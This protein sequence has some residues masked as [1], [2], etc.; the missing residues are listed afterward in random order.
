MRILLPRPPSL[1]G[2]TRSEKRPTVRPAVVVGMGLLALLLLPLSNGTLGHAGFIAVPASSTS[3][4]LTVSWNGTATNLSN[5]FWG[6]DVRVYNSVGSPQAGWWNATPLGY[7][8]W[9]G[10]AVA[11]GY[12]FTSNV[13]T[14]TGGGTYVPPQNEAQFVRWCRAVGCQA[15]VQ[16]PAEVNDPAMA[17]Y[18]VAYTERTL[19][20]HPAYWEIG[21]EPARWQHF[22]QPWSQWG[23]SSGSS[24][25]AAGYAQVVHAYIAAM[26]T[27]DRS[28][29]FVGLPGTGIGATDETTWLGDT[30][31]VNGPD[32]SA[33][34]IH[35]YPAG[36]G[37]GNPTL[38][39][40]LSSLD[41]K[42]SLAM[43]VPADRAAVAAACRSC[44]PIPILVTEFGSGILGGTWDSYMSTYPEVPYI[45]AALIQGISLGVANIDLFSFQGAY[46]GSLYDGSGTE[47]PL[48]VFY[49]SILPHLGSLAVPTN[50][51][52]PIGGAYAIAALAEG[53]TVATLL[54]VNANAASTLS[55]NLAPGGFPQGVTTEAH[56]WNQSANGP[57]SWVYG[58]GVGTV[59]L[60]PASVLLLSAP[61]STHGHPPDVYPVTFEESGLPTGTAWSVS[62]ASHILE[63]TSST[64]TTELSNGSYGFTVIAPTGFAA[65]PSSGS[66]TVQGTGVNLPVTFQAHPPSVYPVSF[67]EIGLPTNTAWS[68]SIA[69]QIL[70]STGSSAETSLPNGSYPFTV[71]TVG[72]TADPGFGGVNVRGASVNVSVSF[73]PALPSAYP[74]TF[75][76]DGI[77][78]GTPWSVSVANFTLNS[79]SSS[80]ST[81]LV[82]GSYGFAIGAPTGFTAD[83]AHG[84]VTV[85]GA[86]V[87]VPVVF[88]GIPPA[89]R[90]YAIY[91]SPSGLAEGTT[92]SVKL[93]S[94]TG[95]G[96]GTI[97]FEESNG[98]YGFSV[99]NTPSFR[100]TPASGIVTVAGATVGVSVSFSPA[101]PGGNSTPTNYSIAFVQGGLPSGASWW[102][103]L[104]GG[105]TANLSSTGSTVTFLR[106]NG[107]Y[108]YQLGAPPGYHALVSSGT[109][110]LTGSPLTVAVEFR[111]EASEPP[112]TDP[113]Q[114]SWSP[115]NTVTT[116]AIVVM[117]AL[118]IACAIM[119][120]LLFLQATQRPTVQNRRQPRLDTRPRRGPR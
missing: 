58:N 16:V 62:I 110:D 13:I 92:W 111:A 99:P 45:G 101:N 97:G 107:S 94:A 109:V 108:A 32:L 63:T 2:R 18:Y 119:V 66:V 10:G 64:T 34:A 50:I 113:A 21:N 5:G 7:V 88:Q 59:S 77:P 96:T 3:D 44:G 9:P 26:R 19:G 72:Y 91:F 87:R 36:T 75:T 57:S 69:S 28:I 39:G 61:I 118:A 49:S 76:E 100:P 78:A 73:Q 98:T 29:R 71:N 68:V 46:P 55:V 41:G 79:T 40:F 120:D 25:T 89:P 23:S 112:Q 31:A 115:P 84:S 86:G 42:G 82:N 35:V 83:P 30:V 14:S 103:A 51:S 90:Y 60:D 27:V 24:I 15:I 80:V 52:G 22:N 70:N 56:G 85:R 65:N 117:G 81:A 47:M 116:Y 106:V 37:S 17:A 1:D 33:V 12:N 20:F 54:V 43:R 8:R 102:V 53:G 104:S 11:D 6:A 93:G 4:T 95:T 114:S 38:A 48:G 74:V 105:S 67:E